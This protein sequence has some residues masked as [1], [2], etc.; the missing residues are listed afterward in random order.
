[1]PRG[2]IRPG[3]RAGAASPQPGLGHLRWQ[4]VWQRRPARPAAPPSQLAVRA[5]LAPGLPAPHP[6]P[7]PV[8]V[9]FRSPTPR[10]RLGCRLPGPAWRGHPFAPFWRI[11]LFMPRAPGLLP[12][13]ASFRHIFSHPARNGSRPNFAW[14]A[15]IW[16]KW[17]SPNLLTGDNAYDKNKTN[18]EDQPWL[19]ATPL[20]T[21]FRAT[22]GRY[23]SISQVY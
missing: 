10:A 13:A 16:K 1:M 20:K 3:W 8:V 14:R 5:A 19:E 17:I 4:R 22:V 12:S 15:R 23:G 11:R 2:H 9:C 7:A 21:T 18:V 6:H